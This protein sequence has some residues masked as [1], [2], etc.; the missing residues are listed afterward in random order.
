MISKQTQTIIDMLS[1]RRRGNTVES[2]SIREGLIGVQEITFVL[3]A[4][5]EKT[6]HIVVIAGRN[7]NISF[8]AKF[9]YRG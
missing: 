4:P 9:Q 5:K 3:K 6:D 1:G 8:G 7:L 2:I